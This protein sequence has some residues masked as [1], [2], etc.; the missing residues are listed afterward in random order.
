VWCESPVTA[1]SVATIL[2]SRPLPD[3]GIL[4]NGQIFAGDAVTPGPERLPEL[5]AR[6]GAFTAAFVSSAELSARNG[7]ARGFGVYDDRVAEPERNRPF[8]LERRAPA[9][10]ARALDWLEAAR[11][12]PFFCFVHL[13]DPHGP[14][15][16]PGGPPAPTGQ[17]T[18]LSIA[19]TNFPL[20]A[21][22]AYQAMPRLRTTGDYLAA[23]DA[24]IAGVDGAIRALLDGL[25]RFGLADRTLVIVTADHGES[26][27]AHGLHFQH[28]SSLCEEQIRVPL[29]LAGPGIAPGRHDTPATTA[30][31]TPTM[32][33]AAGVAVPGLS[34]R[35]LLPLVATSAAGD[36]A[37]GLRGRWRHAML[38]APRGTDVDGKWRFLRTVSKD[39]WKL[40]RDRER[41]TV[42][43]YDLE[44]DPAESRNLAGST[45]A[46][47]LA[48]AQELDALLV[49]WEVRHRIPDAWK[50]DWLPP[51]AERRRLRALGYLD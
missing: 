17:G 45:E 9:T 50:D 33:A 14:Y 29:L 8:V 32:L 51:E 43:L 15:D 34:G 42:E 12:S 18:L 39:G 40:V 1:P 16:P 46:N 24:E 36:D 25:R 22:P 11:R 28:G 3:H 20:R 5:L 49:E 38:S 6:R 4:R 44:H 31:I 2:T 19:H 27:G 10:V 48:R 26:L 35:S 37:S 30:D 41:H 13:N 23:Y 21:L 47:A 7:F